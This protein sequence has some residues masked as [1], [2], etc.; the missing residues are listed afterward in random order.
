MAKDMNKARRFHIDSN[1]RMRSDIIRVDKCTYH[2]A[3]VTL[4]R[5]GE[6]TSVDLGI[7]LDAEEQGSREKERQVR[8][9]VVPVTALAETIKSMFEGPS[10]CK[11]IMAVTETSTAMGGTCQI[12]N[13]YLPA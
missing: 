1:R 7:D 2:S 6:Q 9:G 5:K 8:D 10:L 11:S 12:A 4:P 13:G 3:F